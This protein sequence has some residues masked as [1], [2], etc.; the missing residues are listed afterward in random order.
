[1]TD[2]EIEA[3]IR[4]AKEE[5]ASEEWYP[6]YTFA[7]QEDWDE[8]GVETDEERLEALVAATAEVSPSDWDNPP[9]PGTALEPVCRGSVIYQF[10]WDS[11]HFGKLM[12]F[13]FALHKADGKLFVFS[14]HKARYE[15]KTKPAKRVRSR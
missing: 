2:G 14:I 3:G 6:A 10:V 7:L 13:R 12:F 11:A 9:P 4:R 15:K 8:L 1:M 5:L